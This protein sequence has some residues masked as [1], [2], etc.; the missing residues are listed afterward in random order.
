MKIVQ[1][2]RTQIFLIVAFVAVGILR[3]Y[4]CFQVPLYTTD[5]FRNLGYGR[6]FWRLGADIY[7]AM[8]EDFSPAPY[9]FFW[10]THGYTYP[11]ATILF[12]ALIAPIC[13]GLVHAKV[14]LTILSAF[15][16]WM[17]WR[18]TKDRWIAL[19]YWAN[20]ISV[21]FGS[22]EG[23]F[24][25][26]VA[27]WM[28]LGIWLLQKKSPWAM[29]CLAIAIQAKLFPVFL[30]PT[31]FL[32]DCRRPLKQWM[33]DISAF[34]VGFL[35]S[36]VFALTGDYLAK[37][38][39]PA[40]IPHIN[41]IPWNISDLRQF[42]PQP[43]WL[44]YLNAVVSKGTLLLL[45]GFSYLRYRAIRKAGE[46]TFQAQ[47]DCI[48]DYA[49]LLLF[50]CL[51]KSSPVTQDW[52]LMLVPAFALTIRH[53]RHRRTVF[54]IAWLFGVRSMYSMLIGLIGDRNPSETMQVLS[55]CLYRF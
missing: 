11:A 40:Y 48:L 2:N 4:Y 6:E 29:F 22:H 41:H 52:H 37:L 16:T 30:I 5:L 14:I 23:Q 15:N 9:Q 53:P 43:L 21:W 3:L 7:S 26:Y 13:A 28:I 38:F 54:L 25:P 8:P 51:L 24:E 44:I 39:S 34:A 42:R 18:I 31:F 46:D 32:W 20:P 55:I 33:T 47:L 19:L 36:I 17:T 1:E 49:P 35:P 50:I 45:A 10:S 27:T 12:F